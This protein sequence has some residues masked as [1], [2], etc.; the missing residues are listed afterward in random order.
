MGQTASPPRKPDEEHGNLGCAPL[1]TPTPNRLQRAHG[2]SGHSGSQFDLLG[3]SGPNAVL[4]LHQTSSLP[5][6]LLQFLRRQLT[7]NSDRPPEQSLPSSSSSSSFTPTASTSAAAASATHIKITHSPDTPTNT[8]ATTVY[9]NGEDP[10]YSCPHCSRTLPSHISLVGHL[11]IH[12]TETGE[13]V[14][15]TP[16]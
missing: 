1:E 14:A 15:G 5:P 11:Q 2:V 6:P 12:R 4:G 8:N 16:A 10:I 9:T 13:P 3:T 7:L